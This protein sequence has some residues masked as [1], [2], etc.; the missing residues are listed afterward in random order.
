[1]LLVGVG[2]VSAAVRRPPHPGQ[3]AVPHPTP[4]P[5]VTR[6]ADRTLPA[7]L[8]PTTYAVGEDTASDA[9]QLY[10]DPTGERA[11]TGD[12][13]LQSPFVAGVSAGGATQFTVGMGSAFS[14]GARVARAE[15]TGDGVDDIVV[16][17]GPGSP[18]VVRVV[19]GATHNVVF[20]FQPFEPTFTGGVNVAVGDVTGDG[21]AD[22]IVTPDQG[23]GPR[24]QVYRG[25]GLVKIADFFGIDD[26][27]FR[28]GARA[29]VGD[30]NGDGVGDLV[31]AAGFGGGPR[32][33]VYD[34][35]SITGTP[36]KLFNDVFVFEDTLRNGAYVAAGDLNGDGLSDLFAAGGP[37]GAPRVLVLDGEGLMTGQTTPLANF[38]AGDPTSRTGVR[39]ATKNLDGDGRADLV[40]GAGPGGKSDVMVY[41]GA[42]LLGSPNPTPDRESNVFP[43]NDFADGVFVGYEMMAKDV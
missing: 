27:N 42:T 10:A 30:F 38:F 25:L 28:G 21:V 26:P 15:I 5:T 35:T 37:G 34:G 39:I 17:S 33:A 12:P 14:G 18:N 8:L 13:T 7:F 6:L 22:L 43:S 4:R 23:G 32:V 9:S 3:P 41:S 31:V 20:Q 16:G 1:M 29:A 2:G 40:V 19:N 24:V 36:R 11:R